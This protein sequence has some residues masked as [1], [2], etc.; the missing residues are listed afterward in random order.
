MS[1]TA[2]A[3]LGVILAGGRST[4]MGRDKAFLPIA[5][6][7]LVAHV[8][9]RFAPQVAQ[10]VVNANGDHARFAGLG[11]RIIG[12]DEVEESGFSGEGP[13][14]GIAAALT[15]AR[16]EGF[17]HAATVP[18]DAPL[19]P[20]DLVARLAVGNSGEIAV[21]GWNSEMEPLFALWP[22]AF[23]PDVHAELAAGR[24]AVHRLIACLPH[25]IVAFSTEVD[26]LSPFLNL[27]T[28]AE[29]AHFACG[30]GRSPSSK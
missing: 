14:A 15:F 4:R 25:R 17:S 26:G 1:G 11:L 5:G 6:I 3:T 30:T 18:V 13:L 21:A 23:E 7:P 12:D 29:L 20:V 24:R 28:P 27:N 22:V 16:R 9:R 8:A 19:V 10:L 2:C